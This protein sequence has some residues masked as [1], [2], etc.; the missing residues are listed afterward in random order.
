MPWRSAGLIVPKG[1]QHSA[2]DKVSNTAWPAAGGLAM[3]PT[4]RA[5]D[6]G[7]ISSGQY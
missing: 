3:M 7:H 6:Y 2:M 4:F 1:M 5:C